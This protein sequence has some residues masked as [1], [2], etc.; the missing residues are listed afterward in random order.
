VD[1]RD[2][3]A[4]FGRLWQEQQLL[5]LR[6]ANAPLPFV[7]LWNLSVSL[8]LKV[9]TLFGE[10]EHEFIEIQLFKLFF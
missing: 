10:F 7:S 9:K 3:Y 5:V 4:I 6:H 8:L 1:I 2:P